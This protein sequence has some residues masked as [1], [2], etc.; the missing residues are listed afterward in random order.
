MHSIKQSG[1]ALLSALLVLALCSALVAFILTNQ[2]LIISQTSLALGG[3]KLMLMLEGVQEW[4]IENLKTKGN[5]QQIK[6]FKRTLKGVE[7]SGRVYALEGRFN[8]NVLADSANIPRFA[9]L[10]EAVD[11]TLSPVRAEEIATQV[12]QYVSENPVADS[13]L[14]SEE[15]EEI[16]IPF[17]HQYMVKLDELRLLSTMPYA[18]YS[19]LALGRH[20]YLVALPNAQFQININHASVFS[21][22]TVEGM[23]LS[24]AKKLI[25]CR[26]RAGYFA[27]VDD[28]IKQCS[29][30]MLFSKEELSARNRFFL[31]EGAAQQAD[32]HLS[33]QALMKLYF[34]NN[35]P[36]V[37]IIWQEYNGE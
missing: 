37:K 6:Q 16:A 22:L 2:R 9:D 21:L 23:K 36:Q 24:D 28:F 27:S 5:T 8:V 32:Q 10:I 31:V 20:P 15:S 33:M 1:A 17:P 18:L 30:G 34:I 12:N 7:I 19:K 4:A 25:L 35:K 13:S 14:L 26:N 29:A 3:D 11:K